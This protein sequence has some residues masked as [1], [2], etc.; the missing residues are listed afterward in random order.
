MKKTN[1]R[2]GVNLY[3]KQTDKFDVSVF[4]ILLRL[5]LERKRATAN[6]LVAK[7][8]LKGCNKYITEREIAA[9]LEEICT[10]MECQ[11]LKKGEEQIIQLY[12][13]TLPQYTESA[14]ELAGSI[15]FEPIFNGIDEAKRDLKDDIDGIVNNKRRYAVERCIENMCCDE[16][17]GI[18][19]D[20]YAEDI[21]AIDIQE[22][23]DYVAENSDIA[24]MA[25]SNEDS[26]TLVGYVNKYLPFEERD[27]LRFDASYLKDP[28]NIKEIEEKTDVSQSKLAIGISM[29][30][31]PVGKEWYKALV[32]NELFGGSANSELFMEAREKESLCYY[33]SSKLLRFKSIMIIE[34]GIE[35][36]NK[37]KVEEIIKDAFKKVNDKDIE[38]AKNSIVNS[39]KASEDKAEK[40]M[41]YSLGQ[42]ILNS[43]SDMEESAEEIKKVRSIEGVF[44]S[45]IFDTVYMLRS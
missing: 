28:H 1:I 40:I 9:R 45:C 3:A 24:I 10:V 17:Y 2:R 43:P 11:I 12:F 30:V 44:D 41:D 37:E 5:P 36:K 19:G 34:A 16:D 4:C 26:D 32:A 21:D 39:F 8:L 7:A 27:E 14:F 35:S 6:A 42:I 29:N 13:K 31:D 15:L 38:T 18:R 25:V 23:Y 20:G 33:I 22:A